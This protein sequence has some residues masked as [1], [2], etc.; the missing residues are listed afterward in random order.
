M[1]AVVASGLVLVLVAGLLEVKNAVQYP[2]GWK[3]F[4]MASALS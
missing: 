2:P 1:V 3:D 4:V